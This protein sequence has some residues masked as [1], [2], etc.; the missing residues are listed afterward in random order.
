MHIEIP[1]DDY[2]RLATG[3]AAAGYAD[4]TAYVI[5]LADAAPVDPREPLSD[6]ELADSVARLQASFAD[7]EAGRTQDFR[8]AMRDIAAR[9][10]IPFK[11]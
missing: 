7:V 8:E 2:E 6:D 4:V 10:G 1:N 9:H 3:A 5:A 11:R